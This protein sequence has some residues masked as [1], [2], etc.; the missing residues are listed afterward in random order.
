MSVSASPEHACCVLRAAQAGAAACSACT[1]D[2]PGLSTPDLSSVVGPPA[3]CCA[4]STAAHACWCPTPAG[5]PGPQRFQ[6]KVR[7][8]QQQTEG[9]CCVLRRQALERAGTQHQEL[10]ERLTQTASAAAAEQ[11]QN[12]T[13]QLEAKQSE[14]AAVREGAQVGEHCKLQLFRVDPSCT[15][16]CAC[17]PAV[18]SPF[19]DTRNQCPTTS[20]AASS[21]PLACLESQCQTCVCPVNK[22]LAHLSS[23]RLVTAVRFLRAGCRLLSAC[24]Y[25]TM[26]PNA[27]KT[28]LLCAPCC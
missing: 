20:Q 1:L 22:S 24:H 2:M 19:S 6:C 4:G 25:N 21:Q 11:I 28:P 9:V 5:A 16:S 27:A 8:P 3:A 18:Q 17:A 7:F 14:L 26:W 13:D 12:L 23:G 10:Q 15:A